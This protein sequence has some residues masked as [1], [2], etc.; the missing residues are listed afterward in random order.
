[1]AKIITYTTGPIENVHTPV[2]TDL[3]LKYL[4]NDKKTATVRG[5][6]FSLN[7]V[8]T[9]IFDS[10]DI[11][12]VPD[13]SAVTLEI[14]VGGTVEYEVQFESNQKEVQFS[15][16]GYTDGVANAYHRVVHAELTELKK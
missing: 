14:A 16:W 10:G 9:L 12:L 8:K 15:V 7:G 2:T 1:M 11:T 5:R 6:I 3:H 4:N 13:E